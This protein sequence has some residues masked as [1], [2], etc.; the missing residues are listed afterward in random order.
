VSTPEDLPAGGPAPEKARGAMPFQAILLTLGLVA[1]LGIVGVWTSIHISSRPQF[2]GSCHIMN[3]YY[4]SWKESRHSMVA[5]VECHIPPGVTAEFKKKYEALSMVASYFTGT[6]G[7]NPWTEI[8][9][10]ACLRCHE[11]RLLTGKELFGDVLFDHSSHLSGMRRG[12]RLRCTSCHSQIVQGSHIAVTTSTCVLCHFKDQEAGKGMA[13]CT[14]CHHI[15]DKVIKHETL[16]LDHA[17]VGRFGME[18]TWCHARPEGSDGGVPRE[19]CV[20]CHNDPARLQ[21]YDE[22]EMLHRQHVSEHKVDC[23]DCHL[24]IQHVGEPR[25]E[26]ATT[27]CNTCHL[28][29]H[30]PQANLYA[31]IG[32]RGVDPMPDAMFL[33]GVRCEGC[34]LEIP[35]QV[36]NVRRASD[37]S[38]MSC[39]GPSYRKLFLSWKDGLGERTSGLERQISR[40]VAALGQAAPAALADAR[41]NMDLVKEGRG[42]HNVDYAFALLKR[43]H[44]DMNAART[45]RGLSELR[46][47]WKDAPFDSAC[48]RCHQGI[49]TQ[50]GSIFGR[51]FAHEPHLV[52]A[53]LECESCH[54]SH[55]ERGEEEVI[56]FGSAG[57]ESCHHR[58][59]AADC[60][61]CHEGIRHRTVESPLGD[62]PHALHVDDMELECEGCHDL[63]PG[64]AVK[65]IEE[66]CTACHE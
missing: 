47:P 8:E 32:G 51:R 54:R 26:S 36:T 41:F 55:E 48:L 13:R 38:C 50:S 65:L 66:T 11:R 45:E 35:G 19:R 33:A 12:K 6:Y 14:L 17:D 62:F 5:C 15:P 44:E 3:P 59:E 16:T 60:M 20:T 4:E 10:A 18:C 57:C 40:T 24:E 43:S 58:D 2:C 22:T 31:G 42:V 64:K 23:M 7:T 27:A 30:S 28:K 21:E 9:D 34:H 56:R 46:L 29:G 37:V 39:H 49:E 53:E 1:G 25:I 63:S 52:R 61:S